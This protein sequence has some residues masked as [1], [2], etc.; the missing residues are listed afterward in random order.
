MLFRSLLPFWGYGHK[1]ICD[2]H[3][4]MIVVE[5]GIGYAGGHFARWKIFESYA[6]YHAYYGLESVGTCKQD[7]YDVVIPN[8]FDPEDFEYS[9]AKDNYILYLGRVYAGK[10]VD[11]AIQVAEH[12]GQR[13]IVAGQG[14][15]ADMGYRDLPPN[16]EEF[17]YAD[18]GQRRQLMSG[19]Q[20]LIIASR[21]SEPFA[22]VQCEAWLSG[23]PVISPDYAAFAE[24]NQH[25]VTGFRCRTFR[26]YVQAVDRIDQIDPAEC[27]RWGLRF[28]L[29]Q[30][31]PEYERYFQDVM[32]VYTGQ[33]WYQ[34]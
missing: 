17:G 29:E 3:S 12:T 11:V 9:P 18:A 23:T 26:D 6:I 16:I 19:A 32:N 8:Y 25:G 28:S 21:Y 22:G 14:R 13:L 4:D 31:A 27:R 30:I 1:E 20:A 5:P 15:L 7:W 33:G 10:G 34:L 24:Y 2:A